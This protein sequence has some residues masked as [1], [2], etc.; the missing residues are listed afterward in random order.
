MFS[1]SIVFFSI[2]FFFYVFRVISLLFNRRHG[3]VRLSD[4]CV[5]VCVCLCVCLCCVCVCSIG[6]SA[7]CIGG[8][9][10]K[11]RI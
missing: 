4:V 1:E 11:V 9:L 8:K 2:G 5:C 7:N 10:S 3:C 6:E